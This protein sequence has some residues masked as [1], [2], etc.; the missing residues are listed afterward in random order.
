MWGGGAVV[1]IEGR[2]INVTTRGGDLV[3]MDLADGAEI[4]RRSDIQPNPPSAGGSPHY[5]WQVVAYGRCDV[6][7]AFATD[8]GR[9]FAVK[10]E[11]GGT[12]WTVGDLYEDLTIESIWTRSLMLSDS[13]RSWYG[14]QISIC[15][16]AREGT[17]APWLPTEP[18][19]P[20]M[21]GL[22]AEKDSVEQDIGYRYYPDDKR[23]WIYPAQSAFPSAVALRGPYEQWMLAV[24]YAKELRVYATKFGIP[25]PVEGAMAD[26][27]RQVGYDAGRSMYVP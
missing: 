20:F 11:T 9:A 2:V 13:F 16:G 17:R 10:V 3:G 23:I 18:S 19:R 14:A 26:S 27:W 24:P 5:G 12:V 7:L 8:T 22:R 1:P 21:V 4:W 25:T 6:P 15:D